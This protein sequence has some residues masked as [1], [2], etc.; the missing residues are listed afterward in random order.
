VATGTDRSQTGVANDR[1]NVTGSPVN[2]SNTNPAEWFN[3]QA[4]SLEPLG[5]YGNAGRNAVIG[6]GIAD[7]DFST[8]KNFNF[9][10]KKHLQF[11][12]EAFNFLNHPIWSDPNTTLTSNQVNASNLPIAG[13]GNFGVISGTRIDMRN[14]Q[15]SLKLIF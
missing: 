2:L 11:R 10:E 6:P 4:F 8:L 3:I 13:T 9:T 12:F 5:T 14:L 7:W 15:F 1:P